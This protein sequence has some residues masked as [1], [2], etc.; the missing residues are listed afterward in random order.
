M[1]HEVIVNSI[2]YNIG[3]LPTDIAKKRYGKLP[4]LTYYELIN[5]IIKGKTLS[6]EVVFPEWNKNTT[7][8][9]LEKLFIKPKRKPWFNYFLSLISYKYCSSCKEPHPLTNFSVNSST[10]DGLQANCT[11]CRVNL[12]NEY[13]LNNKSIVIYNNSIRRASILKATPS[14]ANLDKIK[15]I[16]KNCPEGYHVDHI[17][18]LQGDT[19][20][21]LHYE[22]NLK[23]IPAKDNLSKSNKFDTETYEHLVP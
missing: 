14:W 18:P 21:G 8:K 5:R 13:Y 7:S 1:I 11:L 15:E 20:C 9:F 22:L 16:Y 23:A 2:L 6:M 3:K 17:I 4:E 12:N 10:D 19:V